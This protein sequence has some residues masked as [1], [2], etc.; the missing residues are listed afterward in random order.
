MLHMSSLTIRT[1]RTEA[2]SI[3]RAGCAS[4]LCCG[5]DVKGRTLVSLWADSIPTE[6]FALFFISEVERVGEFAGFTFLAQTALVML[7]DEVPDTTAFRGRDVVAIWAGRTARALCAV[8]GSVVG[9]DWA[10]DLGWTA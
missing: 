5:R 10:R 3:V 7:A 1:K 9:T 2:S 8:G 6:F 4:D